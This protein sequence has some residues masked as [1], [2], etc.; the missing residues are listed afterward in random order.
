MIFLALVI[1]AGIWDLT[2]YRIP[3]KLSFPLIIS[4]LAYNLFTNNIK[5]SLLGFGVCFLIGLIFWLLGGMGGGDLKMMAGIGS[6]VGLEASLA[7]LLLA[8]AIGLIWALVDIIRHKELKKKTKELKVNLL[9]LYLLKEKSQVLK[10]KNLKNPI[11]YG[12][13]IALSTL[14]IFLISGGDYYF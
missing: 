2:T 9:Q 7:I 1:I 10:E 11:P 6:W 14:V 5:T 13:C 4:G 8:S 12:T 3:N